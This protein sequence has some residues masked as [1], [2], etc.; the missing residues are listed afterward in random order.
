VKPARGAIVRIRVF[1]TTMLAA[2]IGA[3]LLRA[4]W[5]DRLRN[6]WFDAH[7]VLA[8]R[9]V[10]RWPVTVVEIDQ[11]SLRALGQWPWPRTRLAQL[12]QAIAGAGPAA[13]CVNVLMAEPDALSPERVLAAVPI[14]DR[15]ARAA[16]EALPS[17]DAVLAQALDDAPAVLVV[18]GTREP[19]GMSL[20]A[21]P[22]TVR[23]TRAGHATDGPA[24]THYAGALTSIDE[25]NQRADGWGL[26]SAD[27]TR[28]VL[29][30][31]PMVASLG[32]TLVPTLAVEMLRVATGAPAVR[33]TTSGASVLGLSIGPLQVPT[34]PDGAL[35]VYFAGHAAERFVS[36]LEVLEGRVDPSRLERQLVVIGL[37][38]IGL[39]EYFDTPIG[40][41]VSG[42]EIQAELIENLVDGTWLMRPPWAL[43][44]EA[45]TLAVAGLYLV[46][47]TPRWR[48]AGSAAL[49]TAFVALPV[50]GGFVAFRAERLLLD[51]ATP[52]LGL[53]A[54]YGVLL[55]LTL[56]E[57][58]RQRRVLQREVQSQ[59]EQAAHIA[60]ELEAAQRIQNASLPS[61]DELQDDTRIDLH[62][63]LVPAREVGG[64]LYDFF[65][66]D[67]DR[68]FV[69][70]GDVAGK[71]LSASIF[72]AVSKALCKS[73]ILRAPIAPADD[74]GRLMYLANT[75]VSRENAQQLFVTA[76]AAVLDLRTGDLS[77]CNAG[78]DNPYRLHP[79]RAGW[80][81][82]EDGDGPPL[83]AVPDYPYRGGR[84]RLLP[85]E[86]LCLMTDGVTDA[87]NPAGAMYGPERVQR[88]LLGL[89]AGEADARAVVQALRGDVAAFVDG[90]EAAD[91]LTI[92]AFRW[93]GPAPARPTGPG[94]G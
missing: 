49:L 70:V 68:L 50:V 51:A 79:A 47:V 56:T 40:E 78:H 75:E 6:A 37:T 12:I 69:L 54:L 13:V 44:L 7:Q 21:A 91:D 74:L 72:M 87:L 86:M 89:S 55:V 20:R 62:A 9:Q 90:A 66:L 67:G 41:R 45:L 8:P 43:A 76:F 81:R 34:E 60:G 1:G 39:H 65:R 59:R 52:G 5:T 2:L 80:V 94:A 83:C 22:V 25:L 33:L 38:G 32:G 35:R 84:C 29:R 10:E 58:T 36:A 28:G 57:S 73:A 24:L 14:G 4:P 15:W 53:V 48:P 64:D 88:L 19:T 30:R 17:N 61:P 93:L 42:T 23:D 63:V 18:A 46:R 3:L 77:Y 16:L 26:I 71:G 31:I 11:P 27:P 85:G 82:I 92:L